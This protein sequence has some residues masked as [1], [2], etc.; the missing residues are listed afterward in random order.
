MKF[1][2]FHCL[3][4]LCVGHQ[5]EPCL[6]SLPPPPSGMCIYWQG[7]LE[8]SLHQSKHSQFS[9][10][11]CRYPVSLWL[12]TGPAPVCP[13]L[14]YWAAQQC[15]FG[16]PSAEQRIRDRLPWPGFCWHLAQTET[17]SMYSLDAYAALLKLVAVCVCIKKE[18]INTHQCWIPF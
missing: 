5:K 12:F 15:W 13:C 3:M 18:S 1:P 8:L 14:F 7:A 6:S 11:H 2:L 4:F 17:R 10:S 9:V 16:L